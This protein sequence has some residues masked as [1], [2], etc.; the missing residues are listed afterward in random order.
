MNKKIL[1]LMLMAL[2]V[3]TPMTAHANDFKPDDVV[4]FDL[5]AEDWVTTKTARV[6]V[7]VNA[8]VSGATAATTRST[9]VKALDELIKTEW[10]L[11]SFNRGQDAS[12]MEQWNALYEARV[13]ENQLSGLNEQAR[14]VSKPGLQISVNNIDF[15]PTLDE[16]QTA[17]SGLRLK[18]YKMANEHLNALNAALPGRNYR[19]AVVNFT[20]EGS[21]LGIGM[22]NQMDMVSGGRGA[23]AKT[24]MAEM[25]AMDDSGAPFERSEKLIMTAR[26]VLAAVP[27][28][29]AP[30][31]NQA[32]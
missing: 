25:T 14:K 24:M 18:I 26:V 32:R 1:A 30:T 28:M 10:R 16:N 4:V 20:P 31:G 2:A 8:S 21:R 11:I 3:A 19:I 9:M 13:Q 22:T 17:M 27:P 6:L 29:A 23:L 15:S 5:T 12:G 7:N